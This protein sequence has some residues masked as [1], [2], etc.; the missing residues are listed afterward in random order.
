[1]STAKLVI[2]YCSKNG[3]SHVLQQYLENHDVPSDQESTSS[4]LQSAE[5]NNW[6]QWLI[7]SR[8]PN[9]DFA[10]V[11]AN[12][13]AIL[14]LGTK[15]DSLEDLA[16]HG[17]VSM[18]L[19]AL[20]HVPSSLKDAITSDDSKDS[21]SRSRAESLESS[22][23]QAIEGIVRTT[24]PGCSIAS[25]KKCLHQFPTVRDAFQGLVKPSDYCG[26]VSKADYFKWRNG[27]FGAD[28]IGLLDLIPNKDT[29][30]FATLLKMCSGGLESDISS[31]DWKQDASHWEQEVVVNIHE[32][33]EM[34]TSMD[35]GAGIY[36]GVS[37]HLMSGH[38]MAA[39]CWFLTTK[40]DQVRFTQD[41]LPPD[42]LVHHGVLGL[43]M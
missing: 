38:P 24:L 27:V 2:N 39:L 19:S 4:L 20:S 3:L 5:G 10:T 29:T 12:A 13:K 41:Q 9:Q 42:F 40:E 34:I 31:E 28:D 6:A 17:S 23:T 11:I 18:L 37:H 33:L 15:I 26:K 1:M 30:D 21:N 22:E 16:E 32:W 36:L 35:G 14:P 43:T 25:L 8:A 7:L